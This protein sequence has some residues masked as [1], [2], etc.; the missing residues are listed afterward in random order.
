MIESMFDKLSKEQRIKVERAIW[1]AH[2]V[3]AVA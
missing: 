1:D 3:F 2:A